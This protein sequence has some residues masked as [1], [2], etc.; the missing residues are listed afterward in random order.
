MNT[1]LYTPSFPLTKL[2][3]RHKNCIIR[4]NMWDTAKN[5]ILSH[6]YYIKL[7]PHYFIRNTNLFHC[8]LWK[9]Q[10]YPLDILPPNTCPI[11]VH[12]IYVPN[13]YLTKLDSSV[14]NGFILKNHPPTRKKCA[15]IILFGCLFLFEFWM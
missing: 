15:E 12:V 7:L 14:K 13:F 4:V 8:P 1:N 11:E 10:S 9:M 5:T 3:S 2:T 6:R